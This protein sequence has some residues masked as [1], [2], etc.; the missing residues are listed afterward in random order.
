MQAPLQQ[1]LTGLD[2]LLSMVSSHGE[3]HKYDDRN[4]AAS[5]EANL[6]V[7]SSRVKQV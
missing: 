5:I 7:N 1:V 6:K 3:G 2:A 4:V